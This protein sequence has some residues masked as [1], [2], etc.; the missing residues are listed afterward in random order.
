ML[1]ELGLEARIVGG[2]DVKA[3]IQAERDA[4]GVQV[5]DTLA[6]AMASVS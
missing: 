1:F 4:G 5:F 6:E 2:D 3:A